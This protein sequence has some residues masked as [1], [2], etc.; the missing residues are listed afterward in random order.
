M[1]V[2]VYYSNLLLKMQ[3]NKLNLIFLNAGKFGKK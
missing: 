3:L 2:Y 1:N